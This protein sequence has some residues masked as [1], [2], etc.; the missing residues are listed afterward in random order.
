[1]TYGLT[2]SAATDIV[3]AGFRLNGSA[4]SLSFE[5]DFGAAALWAFAAAG[6][7]MLLRRC[8]SVIICL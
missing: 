5:Q 3:F 4:D 6:F 7:G 2:L 8:A 1:M